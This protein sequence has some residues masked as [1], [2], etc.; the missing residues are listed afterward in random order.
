[1]I[2]VV[3]HPVAACEAFAFAA[4]GVVVDQGTGWVWCGEEPR[5]QRQTKVALASGALY[6]QEGHCWG[7]AVVAAEEA[8]VVVVAGPAAYSTANCLDLHL[9]VAA[10]DLA[11]VAD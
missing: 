5:L 6:Y 9:L 7:A 11:V 3:D 10:A 8:Q 4:V 2:A 1:M